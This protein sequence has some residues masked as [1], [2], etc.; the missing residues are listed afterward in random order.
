MGFISLRLCFCDSV[1]I[2]DVTEGFDEFGA[3]V[4]VVD[5]AGVFPNVQCHYDLEVATE[6]D[7]VFFDL[8]DVCAVYTFVDFQSCPPEPSVLAATA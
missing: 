3:V 5:V 7:V 8:N 2:G 1:P 6:V 4:L